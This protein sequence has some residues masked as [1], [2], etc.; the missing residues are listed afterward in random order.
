[1][2]LADI[3]LLLHLL[4]QGSSEAK[5]ADLNTALVGEENIAWLEVA[6]DY[7]CSVKEIHGTQKIVKDN[8][9]VLHVKWDIFVVIENL[10][11]VLIYV[12]H[13][14]EDTL[15]VLLLVVL[16]WDDDIEELDS[17][18]VIFHVWKSTKNGNFSVNSLD[19]VD[20]FEGVGN[21]FYGDSFVRLF[22]CSFYYLTKGSLS[23]NLEEVEV[24]GNGLPDCWKAF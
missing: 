19:A 6:M 17:E 24:F 20:V 12:T 11:Q 16:L 7:I 4:W 3:F 14:E 13:H 10:G 9:C 2:F 18:D 22:G 23:L 8:F 5:V 15:W 21:I 1:M